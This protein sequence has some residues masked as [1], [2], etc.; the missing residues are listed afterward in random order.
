[1]VHCIYSQTSHYIHVYLPAF[2]FQM[3]AEKVTLIHWVIIL[4]EYQSCLGNKKQSD[5]MAGL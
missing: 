2:Y 1:M 5:C 4:E 3:A